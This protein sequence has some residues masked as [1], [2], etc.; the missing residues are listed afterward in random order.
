MAVEALRV[1]RGCGLE[2]H[3]EQDLELFKKN[4]S[5]RHGRRN[6]CKKCANA[7]KR[8]RTD[9]LILVFQAR[10]I[11]GLHCHFCGEEVTKF[12]GRDRDSLA[13]H[14]L[15]GDHENWDPQNKVP[16]HRGCHSRYHSTGESPQAELDVIL[17]RI[18]Q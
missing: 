10:G 4:V 6:F 5:L 15:D 18:T 16:T 8:E 14:S 1:C 7:E 17:G 9:N 13:I 3:T 11:N 2:A 12:K